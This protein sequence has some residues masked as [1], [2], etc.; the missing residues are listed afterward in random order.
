MSRHVAYF[1]AKQ[2]VAL[3]ERNCPTANVEPLRIG[4]GARHRLVSL[5]QRSRYLL[6]RC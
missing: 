4:G 2:P 3:A 1:P 6:A 5:D